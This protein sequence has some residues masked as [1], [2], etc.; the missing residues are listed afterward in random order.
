MVI[1]SLKNAH[2]GEIIVPKIPSFRIKDLAKVVTPECKVN[3]IGIRAG[4]KIH[5][6]MITGNERQDIFDIGKY[7][8]IL[9]NNYLTQRKRKKLSKFT[10]LKQVKYGFSYSSD[11]NKD[12]LNLTDLKKLVKKYTK[13]Y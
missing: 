6:E 7:Y 12:F 4:E 5:E 8:A 1:W 13:Q 3:Y 11:K 2:G 10:K 9:P